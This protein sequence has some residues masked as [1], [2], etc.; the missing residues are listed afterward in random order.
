MEGLRVLLILDWR[1][2]CATGS[3][4]ILV[5][6]APFLDTFRLTV[7]PRV[8]RLTVYKWDYIAQWMRLGVL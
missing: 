5:T 7:Y 4:L 6:I 1:L 2:G 3:W 8:A